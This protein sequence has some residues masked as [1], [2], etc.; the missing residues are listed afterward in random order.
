MKHLITCTF[1]M[2]C[3]SCG[4][5]ERTKEIKNNE[6]SAFEQAGRIEFTDSCITIYA[7]AEIR[8]K[9]SYK[10]FELTFDCKTGENVLGA[11]Y[12]H[13]NGDPTTGYEVFINNNIEPDEWRKTGGLTAVRNFGKRTCDNDTWF[14][15]RIS[16]IGKQIKTWSNNIPIVDYTEPERP[17]RESEYTKRLL[18][19]G[20]FVFKCE[21]GESLKIRNITIKQFPNDTISKSYAKN[22]QEDDIIK[23][24]QHNFPTIDY[25]I[26]TKGGLTSGGAERISRGLGVTY[27]VA[28]NCGLDFPIKND[29]QLLE[30][31]T[32]NK[33]KPFLMPMQAEGREWT[34]M[35]SQEAISQFDYIL[36]DALTWSD[37]RGRRLRLWIP[38][39]TF[40][41]DEQQFM[42]ELTDI[43]CKIIE[44]EPIHVL[45]NP[46]Y[47]PDLLRSDYDRLWTEERMRRIIDAA[48]RNKVALE[49]NNLN[50]IPSYR[51][52][53]LAKQAG[54][55]FTFGTNNANMEQLEKME[56]LVDAIRECHL[57]S[58]DMYIPVSH[59]N[60]EL[61]DI[62]K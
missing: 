57:S 52:I 47:L 21:S 18:S 42:D 48:V 20:H 53:K 17:Y 3:V 33:N 19:E 60:Q 62:G 28:P 39:D 24:H 46:T 51:F 10:N 29:A 44:T 43:T 50:R 38:E 25:H 6:V 13:T 34:S 40:V 5:P 27:A 58:S 9:E 12:F 59:V 30:W 26:H 45:A 14:P 56:Y 1:L 22:E 4:F 16:V 31:L 11:V 55:K 36:T 61:K 32:E 35:F 15:V 54:V 2:L 23:L 8:S 49:L 7:G 41:D 37:S